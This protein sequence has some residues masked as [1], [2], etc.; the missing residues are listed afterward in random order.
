ME[1]TFTLKFK[2]AESDSD[3][4]AVVE[5]LGAAGCTDALVGTG[6]SGLLALEFAREATSAQAALVS[7]LQDV[8]AA[9]PDA[10]LVEAGP[11]LVGLT[12]AADLL[13]VSRQ[14]MRKYLTSYPDAFPAPVHAGA[15]SIW[16]LASILQ[17]LMQRGH[18]LTAP[19]VEVSEAAM[20]FNLAKEAP[21]MD[22]Y[23]EQLRSLLGEHAA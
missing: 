7:A 23:G 21:L 1:Y 3:R 8:R 14:N 19:L 17:F 4:D 18:D 6:V 10:L 11:D 2:L 5:R 16:H 9:L 15:G 22:R 20:Q 12:D 13:G